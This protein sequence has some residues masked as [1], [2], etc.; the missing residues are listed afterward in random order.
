MKKVIL[1]FASVFLATTVFAQD[2]PKPSPE[3]KVQQRV[4]LTDITI[5]YSRPSARDRRIFGNLVPLGELWRTGANANTTFEI[6]TQIQVMGQTLEAG[7]YS[8][9]TIPNEDYW[10]I[11]FNAKTNLWGTAD[12]SEDEEVL[13]VEAQ[14]KHND[15]K[16]ETFTMG[17]EDISQN[18]GSLYF[19]W[20]HT[21]VSLPFAVDVKALAE[22]NI[23]EALSSS[24]EKDKWRVLRNSASYYLNN[25]AN[26]DKA[27]TFMKKSVKLKDDS[28]YSYWL[29]A[30]IESELGETKDAVKS[31]KKA[32]KVGQKA[33]EKTGKDFAYKQMIE[34]AIIEWE[35]APKS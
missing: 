17:I 16:T 15:S 18:G 33:S 4:G 12:Y 35:K 26:L 31:A 20:E 23:A 21:F 10:I 25:K 9:F 2:L 27:L 29:K 14:V 28:W 34:E 6:S 7:K 8:V 3:A 5:E 11:K 1:S 24:D 19:Q 32:L 22:E 30:R 13:V